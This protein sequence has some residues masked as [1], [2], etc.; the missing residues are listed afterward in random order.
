MSEH[1]PD[2]SGQAPTGQGYL[3]SRKAM[4]AALLAQAPF[5]HVMYSPVDHGAGNKKWRLQ[6]LNVQC[7]SGSVISP[8]DGKSALR[9]F[10]GRTIHR[11]VVLGGLFQ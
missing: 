2:A 10:S 4:K 5:D 3:S 9:S 8:G 1:A 7:L 11:Q 6:T